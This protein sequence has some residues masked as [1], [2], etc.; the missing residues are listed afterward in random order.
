MERD[1]K[2][3]ILLK[4]GKSFLFE[5]AKLFGEDW[6]RYEKRER[7]GFLSSARER[8]K[9]ILWNLFSFP[10]FSSSESL[11]HIFLAIMD[12]RTERDEKA[13][14]ICKEK[15][16]KYV[17]LYNL[18]GWRWPC[19]GAVRVYVHPRKREMLATL[20]VSY[21]PIERERPFFPKRRSSSNHLFSL[22]LRDFPFEGRLSMIESLWFWRTQTLFTERS[23]VFFSFQE[24]EED[25]LPARRKEDGDRDC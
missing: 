17:F 16:T 14:R 8:V 5:I 20:V 19:F 21:T 24:K 7:L 13:R 4:E 18:R 11:V 9:K 25:D 2:V 3:W 15:R 10:F 22:C 1:R 6:E 23:A 12:G